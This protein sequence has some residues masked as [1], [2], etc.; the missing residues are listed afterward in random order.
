MVV[1]REVKRCG[2]AGRAG[3]GA[4]ISLETSEPVMDFHVPLPSSVP[5]S[6]AWLMMAVKCFETARISLGQ[7][8]AVAGCDLREFK[9]V[10]SRMGLPVLRHDAVDLA[11]ETDWATW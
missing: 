7:A 1:S 11:S 5:V 6:E 4:G 2:P 9:P 8:A 10:V 3:R